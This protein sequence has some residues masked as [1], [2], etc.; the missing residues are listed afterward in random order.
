MGGGSAREVASGNQDYYG[1][2]ET[3]AEVEYS[4][5][6]P[7]KE[8]LAEVLDDSRRRSNQFDGDKESSEEAMKKGG[9]NN[10]YGLE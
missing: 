7:V 4:E 3:S 10:R 8:I 9:F 5:R 2:D 6:R 1:R